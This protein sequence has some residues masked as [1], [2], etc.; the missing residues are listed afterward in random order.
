MLKR[1]QA[2]HNFFRFAVSLTLL[3]QISFLMHLPLPHLLFV[4]SFA[5]VVTAQG[6]LPVPHLV[7][8][9]TSTDTILKTKGATEPR[10]VLLYNPVANFLETT[11]KFSLGRR[12]LIKDMEKIRLTCWPN[13]YMGDRCHMM[14]HC[15][16]YPRMRCVQKYLPCLDSCICMEM[17]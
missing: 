13:R 11:D 2:A 14:C 4:L 5:F 1:H 17:E 16:E 3:I 7:R 9:Q 8:G 15:A 12:P 6:K 10:P